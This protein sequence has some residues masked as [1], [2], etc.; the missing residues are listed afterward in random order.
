MPILVDTFN[1]LHVTGVLPPDL[2]GLEPDGLAA[3]V[4]ETGFRHDGVWLVCDGAPPRPTPRSRPGVV[5]TWAGPGQSADALLIRLVDRSSAP[6]RITVVTD[7]RVVRKSVRRRGATLWASAHFLSKLAEILRRA[8]RGRSE[9]KR[10][11]APLAP[12]D[13]QRWL[14]EFGLADEDLAL[15]ASAPPG[16]G[17]APLEAPPSPEQP[18]SRS[19]ERRSSTAA[20]ADDA[21]IDLSGID[22]SGIDLAALLS[23]PPPSRDEPRAQRRG[24][25]RTF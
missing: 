19:T 23:I 24:R 6:R 13:V 9:A 4:A 20:T 2:A 18:A 14:H 16:R 5:L 25:R 10:P 8:P 11:A 12:R 7:D 15:R 22:L 21:G 17:V 3:L 1:V